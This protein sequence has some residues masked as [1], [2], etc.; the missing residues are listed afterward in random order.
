MRNVVGKIMEKFCLVL[1][2]LHSFTGNDYSTFCGIG[3]D[4]NY[5]IKIF[6]K[7]R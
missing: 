4:K 2:A 3:K 5:K 6:E 1:P 7:A